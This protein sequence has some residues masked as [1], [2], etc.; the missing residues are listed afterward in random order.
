MPVTS[1]NPY[2]TPA[3]HRDRASPRHFLDWYRA[4]LLAPISGFFVPLP[5][6]CHRVEIIVP[7]AFTIVHE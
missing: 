1:K 5:E 3:P 2:L 6:L 7:A 4:I